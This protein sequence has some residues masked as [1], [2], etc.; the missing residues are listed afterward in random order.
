[1]MKMNDYKQHSQIYNKLVKF[2]IDSETEDLKVDSLMG[3]ISEFDE[4]D[5]TRTLNE[6]KG[7][8]I[9]IY[10]KDG[11]YFYLYVPEGF[12]DTI[13]PDEDPQ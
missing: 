10:M 1:M 13:L 7:D 4:V 8:D 9:Y 12:V 2:G 5:M 11:M 6:T 3:E